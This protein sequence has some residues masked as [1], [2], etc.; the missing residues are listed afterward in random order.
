MTPD[1]PRPFPE[2]IPEVAEW[3]RENGVRPEIVVRDA[4]IDLTAA[5]GSI[6]VQVYAQAD[7]GG[8]L[9]LGGALIAEPLVI[10]NPSRPSA[11][12]WAW[13]AGETVT[14]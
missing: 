3:L 9:M 8:F 11:A 2:E 6:V 14:R 12:V 4:A 10:R 7:G 5:D 1:Q 13:L